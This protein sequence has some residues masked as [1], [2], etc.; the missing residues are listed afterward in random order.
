MSGQSNG[1]NG[2]GDSME[3]RTLLI[4]HDGALL[5]QEGLARWLASFTDLAGIIVLKENN[6]RMWRRIKRE[7]KRSGP[8]RFF[9]VLAFRFYYKMFLAARDK[10]WEERKLG[11]MRRDYPKLNEVAMLITH[12]PNSPEAEKFIKEVAPDL[13]LARCKTLLKENIFSIPSKGTYVMHP[14]ICPEYRNAHGCFWALA[15]ADYEKVGMT[16]LR[17]DK[18]VDTGPIYGYYSYPYNELKESH[19]VV[20]ARVVLDNLPIL[21]KKLVEIYQGE[22]KPLGTKDRHSATWGQPWLTRYLQLKRRARK[23]VGGNGR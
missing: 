17:I 18:G 6:Q 23:R 7:F 3:I 21:E 15:N 2:R 8:V 5:D 14:G 22:A 13:M 9:D 4:C 10:E 20:Q 12:S 1:R 11:E 19:I 16:L